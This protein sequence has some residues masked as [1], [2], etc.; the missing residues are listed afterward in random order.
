MSARTRAWARPLLALAC[1]SSGASCF[2]ERV[3]TRPVYAAPR[4]EVVPSRPAARERPPRVVVTLRRGPRSELTVEGYRP[5]RAELVQT[6]VWET[7]RTRSPD[8]LGSFFGGVLAAGGLALVV[9]G[10]A[11]HPYAAALL[12]TGA[13]LVAVPYL[14]AGERTER[15]LSGERRMPLPALACDRQPLPGAEV[16]AGIGATAVTGRTDAAGRLV[17]HLPVEPRHLLVDGRVPDQLVEAP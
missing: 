11:Q 4:I 8:A 10:S 1:A 14:A 9:S 13:A 6:R 17:F 3:V 2:Q 7:T 12:S 5:C 16:R 15:K